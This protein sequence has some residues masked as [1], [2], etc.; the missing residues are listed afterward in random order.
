MDI[1][2]RVQERMRSWVASKARVL[3]AISGGP[4]SVALAHLLKGLPYSLVLGHVDHQLRKY[5]ARDARF[6]QTLAQQWELPYKTA[7]VAVTSH[8]AAHHL[9]L[10]E[11]ARDLRYKALVKMARKTG[12]SAI[13]TAHNADDQ[14]ETVLMNFLRGAGPSGLAGIPPVR[15]L[16][17]GL[18]LL[19]PMLESS[20]E[21]ILAYLKAHQLPF[22][23][24]LSNRSL[25]FTRNRIRIR[26]L[27]LLEKEYPGI[28]RRLAHTG[29][30]FR[31]EQTLWARKIQREFNKTVR[32]DNKKITVDLP[33]L[34]GYHKALGRR[35]LRHL[36]TGISFQD[37][38]RVFQL[39]LSPH[40]K[41]PVQL[42]GRLQVERKGKELIIRSR[43]FHE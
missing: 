39:A 27:P 25:R 1:Q 40:G 24:D 15:G 2:Q 43:G 42:S 4:D 32:Q 7:R 18:R 29:E 19:R 22:R 3:C 8:A 36:L 13:I 28:K 9:G 6:V 26:V 21:E 41:L 10:E 31:D 37:T 38:E 5:S 14:A 35:I 33:R 11:A 20:R 16:A 30:I 12:C 34:L 23:Q 17:P